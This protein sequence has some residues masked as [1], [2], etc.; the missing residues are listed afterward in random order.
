MYIIYIYIVSCYI[1]IILYINLSNLP[2]RDFQAASWMDPHPQHRPGK[3]LR[4]MMWRVTKRPVLV[5]TKLECRPKIPMTSPMNWMLESCW[6]HFGDGC[7]NHTV[8]WG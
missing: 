2:M 8:F 5:A 3:A 7:A 6:D 4:E 1:Y